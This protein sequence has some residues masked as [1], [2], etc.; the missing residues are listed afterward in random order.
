MNALLFARYARLK[1]FARIHAQVG[2]D[3]DVVNRRQVTVGRMVI[4][5]LSDLAAVFTGAV[6]YPLAILV[7]DMHASS[8]RFLVFN[9]IVMPVN[10]ITLTFIVIIRFKVLR[11]KQHHLKTEITELKRIPETS[12]IVTS[13]MFQMESTRSELPYPSSA[14]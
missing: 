5:L 13:S 1:H 7:F 8:T 6:A 12:R 2:G 4:H 10:I 14:V 3:R 9:V 11:A